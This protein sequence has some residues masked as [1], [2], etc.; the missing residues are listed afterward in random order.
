MPDRKSWT[1]TREGPGAGLGAEIRPTTSTIT[2]AERWDHWLARWRVDR[3]GHRVEPG[4][5]ALGSPTAHSPVF[6]SANYLGCWFGRTHV[7][8]VARAS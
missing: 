5:Y 1:C 2:R 8:N 3:M 4:L 7:W 6:V